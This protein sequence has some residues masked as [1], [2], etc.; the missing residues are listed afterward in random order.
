MLKRGLFAAT[1][2]LILTPTASKSHRFAGRRT[3][4]SKMPAERLRLRK[5]S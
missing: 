3:L 2:M 5:I 4:L 1:G